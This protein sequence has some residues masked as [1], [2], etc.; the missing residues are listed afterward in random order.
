MYAV[1]LYSV[2]QSMDRGEKIYFKDLIEKNEKDCS[3]MRA[4]LKEFTHGIEAP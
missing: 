4:R 2:D 1:S 3:E